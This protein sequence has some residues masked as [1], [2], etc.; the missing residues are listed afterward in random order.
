[1]ALYDG[2]ITPVTATGD[3]SAVNPVYPSVNGHPILRAYNP[4]RYSAKFVHKFYE[5]CILA[6]ISNTDYLGEIKDYGDSIVIRTIPDISVNDYD[7]GQALKYEQYGT[8][9]KTLKIDR[10]KYWAFVTR[11]VDMK[12]TDLKGFVEAWTQDAVTRSKIAIEKE[13]FA[14]VYTFADDSNQGATAGAVSASF[15]LGTDAAPLTVTTSNIVK[16]ITDCGTVLDEQNIPNDSRWMI[17]SM[18]IANIAINSQIIKANEMGESPSVLRKGQDKLGAIDRFEIFRS[19]NLSKGS[20]TSTHTVNGTSGVNVSYWN[21]LFGHI[22]ALTFAAQLTENDMMKNPNG[23]GML[24]RGLTVYGFGVVQ[25]KALGHAR[26]TS[27]VYS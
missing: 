23:F 18:D 17:I 26:V 12:Q 2:Y 8:D 16:F 11:S 4:K 10:G 19:N 21:V 3:F 5:Q 15:N 1:M 24:H 25:P 7:N 14:E 9:Y 27:T 22:S 20:S 13:V 6:Q